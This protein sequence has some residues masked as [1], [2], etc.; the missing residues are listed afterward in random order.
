VLP[1]GLIEDL[2]SGIDRSVIDN[3]P[4]FRQ[5]RL[6]RHALNQPR[7]KSLF[8]SGWSYSNVLIH[9]NPSLIPQFR[10]TAL[11]SGERDALA[12]SCH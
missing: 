10:P 5:T 3:D 11:T 7:Q 2:C 4:A 1:R 8:V 12:G 6:R 9:H